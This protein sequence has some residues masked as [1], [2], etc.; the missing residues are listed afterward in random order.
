MVI[1]HVLMGPNEVFSDDFLH[2]FARIPEV[3]RHELRIP[4]RRTD[5]IRAGQ[6]P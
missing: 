1:V 3:A 2:D 6:C 5:H 4:D